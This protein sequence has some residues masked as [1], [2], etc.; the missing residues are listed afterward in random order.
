[1]KPYECIFGKRHARSPP[2]LN[3]SQN[4]L[5]SEENGHLEDCDAM[6]QKLR[7]YVLSDQISDDNSDDNWLSCHLSCHLYRQMTTQMTTRLSF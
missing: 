1:M 4:G 2:S 7:P 3:M 6:Y 5:R